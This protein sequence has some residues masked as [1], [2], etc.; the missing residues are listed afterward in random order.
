[1]K[2]SCKTLLITLACIGTAVSLQA[3]A[4]S[5]TW[6]Y[7]FTGNGS[8]ELNGLSTGLASDGSAALVWSA[9]AS[10]KADGS[11]S[12]A[13]SA[14]LSYDFQDGFVYTLAVYVDSSGLPTSS[15]SGFF[16]GI[17]FTTDSTKTDGFGGSSPHHGLLALRTYKSGSSTLPG[18]TF[19]PCPDTGGSNPNY[20]SARNVSVNTN[21]ATVTFVLDTTGDAWAY[22]VSVGSSSISSTSTAL[23]EKASLNGFGLVTQQAGAKFSSLSFAAIQVIPEP[24]TASLLAACALL[25]L[26]FLVRRGRR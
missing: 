16:S 2:T 12:G 22:T 4:Q 19:Y 21:T 9:N 6:E 14:W 26:A 8:A 3:A 11:T 18:Y 25:P 23:F 10:F 17:G 15:S 5:T 7:D 24:A 13:G 20:A 1:M